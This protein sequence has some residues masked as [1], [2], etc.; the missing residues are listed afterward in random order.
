MI[1]SLLLAAALT[2]GVGDPAPVPALYGAPAQKSDPVQHSSP[3]Q[4]STPMQKADH[5]SPVQ[6]GVSVDVSVDAC[7]SGSCGHRRGRLFHG[8]ARRARVVV[9]TPRVFVRVRGCRGC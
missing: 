9:R 1:A 5:H 6:K 4:K 8:R 2:G 7:A 3:V